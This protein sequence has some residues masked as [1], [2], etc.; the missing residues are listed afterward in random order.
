[1]I[2]F[3]LSLT[4][5]SNA[6]MDAI[7]SNDSFAKYGVFFSRNGWRTKHVFAD[8]LNKLMPRWLA[9]FISGTVLVM[10]T[11]LYKLAKMIMILSFLFAIF[12]FTWKAIIIYV[13]WGALFSFVYTFIR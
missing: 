3:L 11:E 13:I 10:F 7:M 8:W 5:A 12:G 4:I 6:V 1:M 2:Y 9:V